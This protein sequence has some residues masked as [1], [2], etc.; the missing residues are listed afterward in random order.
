MRDSSADIAIFAEHSTPSIRV[1]IIPDHGRSHVRVDVLEDGMKR[2]DFLKL[3][4]AAIAAAA[5]T[6]AAR[7]QTA[8]KEVRIGYQKTGVLVIA[9]Q[10]GT[11][12]KRFA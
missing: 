8:P 5:S 6:A 12:E 10:Q 9:R 7:A 11:V 3:S 1:T 2:R 4:T